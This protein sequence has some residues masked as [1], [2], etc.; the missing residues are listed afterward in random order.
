M[1]GKKTI[2]GYIVM[3]YRRKKM[4]VYIRQIQGDIGEKW[5]WGFQDSSSPIMEEIIG[6]HDQVMYIVVVIIGLL[7]WLIVRAVVGKRYNRY[8]VDGT[9]IEIVWTILPAIV[10]L[11]IAFPS[12]RLLY[13]IDEVVDVGITVKAIGHQ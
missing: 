6:L 12:L 13:I 7:V 11:L 3:Y 1:S 9:T 10:L 4:I 5:Q 8:L 2:A